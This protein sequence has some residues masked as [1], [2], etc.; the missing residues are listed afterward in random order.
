[1]KSVTSRIL[2]TLLLI[3]WLPAQADDDLQVRRAQWD[4]EESRLL[5]VGRYPDRRAVILVENA[6]TAEAIGVAEVNR[7]ERWRLQIE[8]PARVPCEIRASIGDESVTAA[9]SGAPGDCDSG[10]SVGGG[11]E[12]GETGGAA[13]SSDVVVLAANDLGMHCADLDY[14]VFSILP[15]FNVVRAQVIARGAR[16]ELVG[17]A[18]YTLDYA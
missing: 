13:A 2:L 4:V 7:R 17:G 5:V 9:V 16:P 15:P 12:P 11:E 14:Q 1:M 6:A 3:V 8:S 10:T 18:A